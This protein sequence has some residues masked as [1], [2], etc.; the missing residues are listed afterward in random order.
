MLTVVS[1][2]SANGVA[3]GVDEA[4]DEELEKFVW[5]I[6][7]VGVDLGDGVTGV[8]GLHLSIADSALSMS[9]AIADDSAQA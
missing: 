1:E 2:D 9:A 7:G 5:E 6:S 8:R 3:L 4:D